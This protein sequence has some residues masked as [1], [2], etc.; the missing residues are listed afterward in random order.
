[1]DRTGDQLASSLQ[2]ILPDTNGNRRGREEILGSSTALQSQTSSGELVIVYNDKA[3]LTLRSQHNQLLCMP[4]N[5]QTRRGLAPGKVD[6]PDVTR[7]VM[8]TTTTRQGPMPLVLDYPPL[9]LESSCVTVPSS[10]PLSFT[11]PLPL[12][13]SLPH[14]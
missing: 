4:L 8:M 9:D 10:P 11:L 2:S 3:S 13:L 1:M 12:P 7:D 5:R 6:K 14:H